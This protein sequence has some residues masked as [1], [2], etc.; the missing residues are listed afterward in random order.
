MS[1]IS[2][3]LVAKV[4]VEDTQRHLREKSMTRLKASVILR[5]MNEKKL[6]FFLMVDDDFMV[7]TVELLRV[8]LV[9]ASIYLFCNYSPQLFYLKI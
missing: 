3:M 8:F 9:E 2:P 7:A 5:K 1:R 4:P 6:S